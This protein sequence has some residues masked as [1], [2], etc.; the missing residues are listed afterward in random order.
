MENPITELKVVI[1]TKYEAKIKNLQKELEDALLFLSHLE[2]TL[3][4][5]ISSEGFN[6]KTTK[7]S[8][9]QPVRVIKIKKSLSKIST[10]KTA[11]QR[12]IGALQGMEGEFSTGELKEKINSDA[13][14][15]EIK[16]GTFAG[17]FADLIKEKKILV[18]QKRKGN[19]GGRYL[20]SDQIQSSI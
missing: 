15:K 2:E 20:K 7:F 14:G 6:V 12:V 5:E 8:R 19:Q 13:S 11:E 3:A 17:I 16:K 9:G 18:V 10:K 4:E 1:K